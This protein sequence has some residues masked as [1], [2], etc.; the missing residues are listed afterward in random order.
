M[1]PNEY[2]TSLDTNGDGEVTEDD[3][4]PSERLLMP[5]NSIYPTVQKMQRKFDNAAG[6]DG[7]NVETS[8]DNWTKKYDKWAEKEENEGKDQDDFAEEESKGYVRKGSEF[9]KYSHKIICNIS[10]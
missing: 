8:L 10:W 9:I 7:K 6:K 2:P 1:L 3:E 5:G 4:E